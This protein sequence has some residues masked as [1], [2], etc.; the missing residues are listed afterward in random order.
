M[1][2]TLLEMISHI[3]SAMGSDDVTNYNDTVESYAVALCIQQAFYDAAVELNL[4]EHESMFELTASGDNAKPVLMTLPTNAT[5]L[6]RVYYDNKETGDTYSNMI[7]CTFMPFDDFIV[8]QNSL[9][10]ADSDVGEMVVTNNSE[11]FNFMYRTN[12]WPR[13]YTTMD[14]ETI[15]FDSIKIS[16]DT[17]TLAKA[18]T[19]AYGSVYPTFTMSNGA[20]LDL[21][22]EQFPYVLAKAKT[23]AFNELKQM[24]NQE[25]AAETRKQKIV[26]Q[27]RKN[28]VTQDPWQSTGPKYGRR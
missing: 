5:R 20:Y 10:Q 13:Y 1:R 27:K 21:A 18:K 23:R 19:M 26:L 14:S 6:D 28:R 16:V 24:V 25:S 12:D 2:L 9:S 17:T 4:P 8:K 22:P 3:L 15:L 7:Q 11:S